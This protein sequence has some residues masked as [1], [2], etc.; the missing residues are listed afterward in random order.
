MSL[1]D[2]KRAGL[3]LPER[4][5]GKR[6]LRSAVNRPLLVLVGAGAVISSFLMY[7]G[8]GGLLTWLG[9]GL[10]LVFLLLFTALSLQ[11]VERWAEGPGRR[12]SHRKSGRRKG[13][14]REG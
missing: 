14:D 3:I 5:W 7:A 8:D 12:P 11:A 1:E 10:Y 2:L 4:E 9:M 13:E 6:G